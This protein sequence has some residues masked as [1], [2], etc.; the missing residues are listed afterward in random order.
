VRADDVLMTLV[1]M[2]YMHDRP[3]WQDS[4]LRMLD[5]FVD[6]LQ[7]RPG[8]GVRPGR[9]RTCAGRRGAKPPER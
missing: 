5:V 8:N 6:G 1:G 7:V 3:G 2:C 4:V 9:R